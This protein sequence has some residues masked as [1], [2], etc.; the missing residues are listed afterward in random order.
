[1]DLQLPRDKEI[2]EMMEGERY[3]NNLWTKYVEEGDYIQVDLDIAVCSQCGRTGECQIL[4]NPDNKEL[5]ICIK[6][7]GGEE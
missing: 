5:N 1:M 4:R 3:E 6:C 7:S 2:L